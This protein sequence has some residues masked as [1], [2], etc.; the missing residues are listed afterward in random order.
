MLDSLQAGVMKLLGR[1]MDPL[2]SISPEQLKAV[3]KSIEG[4]YNALR[5]ENKR[6]KGVIEAHL[7][8]ID[9]LM[10]DVKEAREAVSP[11]GHDV[12]QARCDEL[13]TQLDELQL[14]R[15]AERSEWEAKHAEL[16]RQRAEGEER[17]A[18]LEH[19]LID[20]QRQRMEAEEE[21]RELEIRHQVEQAKLRE[22][23]ARMQAQ[24]SRQGVD[25]EIRD[26]L[27]GEKQTLRAR[28]DELLAERDQLEA[29]LR[30]LE[31]R[32]VVKPSPAVPPQAPPT[33]PAPAASPAATPAA[34]GAADRR[35]L[36]ARLIR[37]GK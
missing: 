7:Q 24:V 28:V 35:E 16:E 22:E 1:E 9:Q 12:L 8:T 5:D 36:L 31:L 14:Q 10:S 33:P 19:Q 18:A 34:A 15:V 37:G 2:G 30:D 3:L 13:A 27:D 26:R 4:K 17:H 20:A 21:R 32:A 23:I 11:R 6:L 29:K 25:T